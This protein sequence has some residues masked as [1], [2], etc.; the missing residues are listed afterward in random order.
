MRRLMIAATFVSLIFGGCDKAENPGTSRLNIRMTDA[1]A[2]YQEVNVDIQQIEV[3]VEGSGWT[4]MPT[5]A[6]VYN[7]LTLTNGIDT[8]LSSGTVPSGLISQIRFKLGPANS[9]KAN[10]VV[11]PMKTPSAMQSGLKIQVHQNLEADYTYDILLDFDANQSV[12]QTGN[13]DYKLKPVIRA[14]TNANSGAIRGTVSVQGSSAIYGLIGSDTV[15]AYTSSNGLFLIQGA[16]PG[17]Y[18]LYV[19]PASGQDT[20]LTGVNVVAGQTT[21]VGMINIQP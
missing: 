2:A 8:L 6:G 4:T 14:I 20:T 12:V 18:S 9:I 16:K 3:H 21:D 7:L 10:G 13:G 15:T 19:L 5:N 11:Y 1:P 17:T